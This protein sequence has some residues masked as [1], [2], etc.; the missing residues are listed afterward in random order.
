MRGFI[1]L[2]LLSALTFTPS[3]AHAHGD[4][5]VH[6]SGIVIVDAPYACTSTDDPHCTLIADDATQDE[7]QDA[8]EQQLEQDEK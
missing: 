5:P 2:I 4:T 1:I 7:K 8:Q 3:L 6:G